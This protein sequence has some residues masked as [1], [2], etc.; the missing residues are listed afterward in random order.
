[1][2]WQPPQLDNTQLTSIMHNVCMLLCVYARTVQSLR[3]VHVGVANGT[4]WEGWKCKLR[5]MHC[6]LRPP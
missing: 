6:M 1:M 5:Q 4:L 2:Q 3:A